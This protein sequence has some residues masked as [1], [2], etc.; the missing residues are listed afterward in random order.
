MKSRSL[1]LPALLAAAVMLYSC[2]KVI[3]SDEVVARLT[4]GTWKI[5]HYYDTDHDETSNYGGYI[6]TFTQDSIFFADTANVFT[7]TYTT[8]DV[9]EEPK[10]NMS[11][12]NTLQWGELNRNWRVI[13]M[14]ETKVKMDDIFGVGGTSGGTDYLTFEQN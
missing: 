13:E 9:N 4:T 3:T 5:S 7:G 12:P 1:L 10:I 8:A 6:F 11:M 2:S 14:T